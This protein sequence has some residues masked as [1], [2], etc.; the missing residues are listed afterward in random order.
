MKSK[1]GNAPS[2]IKK[3]MNKINL[4]NLLIA[5][6]SSVILS[7]SAFADGHV[8]YSVTADNV[9]E[10]SSML[11]PGMINMFSAYPETFRMDV[12][13]NGGDCTL[14]LSLIHI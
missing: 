11:T 13:E 2:T 7:T 8:K 5:A 10:Y 4:K 9:S 14:T 6:V 3:K 12:Y 1:K